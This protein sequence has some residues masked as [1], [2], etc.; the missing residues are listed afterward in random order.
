MCHAVLAAL[1]LDL[2]PAATDS[3]VLPSPLPLRAPTEKAIEG[4]KRELEAYKLGLQQAQ[5][6]R[7]Q[8]QVRAGRHPLTALGWGLLELSHARWLPHPHSLAS[9]SLIR[10]SRPWRRSRPAA[11]SPG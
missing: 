4:I 3:D 9:L 8:G 2:H 7:G 5:A 10:R 6:Q 1:V 11:T